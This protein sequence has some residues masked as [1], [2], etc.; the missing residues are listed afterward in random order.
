MDG[1]LRADARAR[2]A[3]ADEQSRPSRLVIGRKRST[4]DSRSRGGEFN[5]GVPRRARSDSHIA[6]SR[7]DQQT[8]ISAITLTVLTRAAQQRADA[9]RRQRREDRDRRSSLV[10]DPEHDVHRD[11]R[12]AIR[13]A[14]PER[15]WTLAQCG[16]AA[17]ARRMPR[18]CAAAGSPRGG[19]ERRSGL[20]VEGDLTAGMSVWLT[21]RALAVGS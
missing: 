2:Q 6:S 5:R 14:R 7:S 15:R 18:S 13:T 10:Q 21:D 4:Q 16:E 17:W 19:D 11:E 3:A 20:Q 1:D 12:S 8:S 9:G